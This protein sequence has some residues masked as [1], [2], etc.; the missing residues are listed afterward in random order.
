MSFSRLG[1]PGI[2]TAFH[3]DYTRQVG[4]RASWQPGEL[5]ASGHNFQLYD[6]DGRRIAQ[7][8]LPLSPRSG[9]E[10]RLQGIRVTIGDLITDLAPEPASPGFATA[11]RP[12]PMPL[13]GSRIVPQLRSDLSLKIPVE[14]FF[15]KVRQL[16]NDTRTPEL[17]R[18]YQEPR[19]R[20]ASGLTQMV[21]IAKSLMDEYT[22]LS[23]RY[24]AME[25][26]RLASSDR[27]AKRRRCEEVWETTASSAEKDAGIGT[28][29]Q[30]RSSPLQP[31]H[32]ATPVSVLGFHRGTTPDFAGEM[33]S[34]DL[35]PRTAR[36]RWNRAGNNL[37]HSAPGCTNEITSGNDEDEE[38]E[39]DEESVE[40]IGDDEHD[41]DH[42]ESLF[43]QVDT[44]LHKPLAIPMAGRH[45]DQP[46]YRVT[47]RLD[48]DPMFSKLR[49]DLTANTTTVPATPEQMEQTFRR[50]ATGPLGDHTLNSRGKQSLP[51]FLGSAHTMR[52]EVPSEKATEIP[53]PGPRATSTAQAPSWLQ[54][55]GF[56]PR[57]TP[58]IA[59]ATRSR[60]FEAVDAGRK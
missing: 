5:R 16:V 41:N 39:E 47:Q 60:I 15:A 51:G 19:Q 22:R 13:L 32:V 34:E 1:R 44:S 12:P 59:E 36:S 20:L 23:L 48:L 30:S 21:S 25:E 6:E 17:M 7:E 43:E 8:M 18:C 33:T 29:F 11:L 4:R 26:E 56:T 45:P 31:E 55:P 9:N 53:K 28:S 54:Y 14:D 46:T 52:R 35:S 42:N 50:H 40:V 38:D 49:R 27:E 24:E 37:A 10:L 2:E 3:C 58:A 57:P